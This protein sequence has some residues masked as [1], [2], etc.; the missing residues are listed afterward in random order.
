VVVVGLVRSAN[1]TATRLDY[2][3]DDMSGP[4]IEVRQFVDNDVSHIVLSWIRV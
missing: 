2:L 3:V 1:E 4:P